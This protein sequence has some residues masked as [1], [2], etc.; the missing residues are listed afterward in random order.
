LPERR[1]L[2]LQPGWKKRAKEEVRR[3]RTNQNRTR[4]KLFM[5]IITEQLKDHRPLKNQCL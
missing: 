2:P 5:A 4:K 3:D 1:I